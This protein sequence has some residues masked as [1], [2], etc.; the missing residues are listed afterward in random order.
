MTLRPNN[1]IIMRFS[2]IVLAFL[3]SIDIM[4]QTEQTSQAERLAALQAEAVA[5]AKAAEEAA[6]AAQEAAKALKE[7]TEALKTEE[8]SSSRMEKEIEEP[9][10]QVTSV[11][12]TSPVNKPKDYKKPEKKPVASPQVD[13]SIY[14]SEDA[15]PVIDGKISWTLELDVPGMTAQQLYDKT[16]DAITK[17]T[18][19]ENQSEKSHIAIVQ[20][21]KHEIVASMEE[22][23]VMS[24]SFF[25]LDQTTLSYV[26]QALCTD[27]HVKIIMKRVNYV[28][29][30]Q[31][32]THHYKAEEIIVD[33]V[34]VNKKRTRLYPHFGKFRRHTI[35]RKNEIFKFISNEIRTS[36]NAPA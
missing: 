2:L 5:K 7:A 25:S 17:L 4:A 19:E 9:K 12:A 21:E 30:D 36:T 28:Y 15:V 13:M 29:Q 18:Q 16:I 32:K 22:N 24:S 35:D 8:Q 1:S 23:M 14:L 34:A 20:E 31:R 6:R 26:L 11:A 27:G 3:L 33:S 10:S